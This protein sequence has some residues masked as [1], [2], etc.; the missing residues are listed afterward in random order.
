MI[1][2]YF[3]MGY[4]MLYLWGVL[5]VFVAMPV[6]ADDR[7]P[8]SANVCNL[9][10]GDTI[11]LA[12]KRN[13]TFLNSQLER[14]V[15]KFSLDVTEDR[16]TPKF[17]VG[18]S[19]SWNPQDQR[20]GV[21]AQMRLRVPTGGAFSLSLN[22]NLSKNFDD[23]G[24]Q[25]VSFSQP[26]LKGAWYGVESASVRQAR[27]AEQINI[28]SFRQAAANLVVSVIRAYRSLT[29]AVRAVEISEASLQRAHEQLEA[30]RSLISAGR[31]AQREIGRSEAT[32]ANRELALVQTQNR[33]EDVLF[34][35]RDI[36]ELDSSTQ[37]R[38][39]LEE[40]EVDPREATML[41][42]LEE[43][44]RNRT[45]YLQ[46]RLRI[47]TSR[48]GLMLA[49]NNLLPDLSIQ[50]QWSH[51]NT[52]QTNRQVQM[53][54]SIPL[55]DRAP[56]LGRLQADN[57]LSQ[58]ERS[59]VKLRESIS[60]ELRQ[61][62]NNMKVR[63]RLTELAQDARIL[64][65]KNLAVEEAKFGQGLSSTFEVAS[66]GEE[67]VR[68]EQ[69]EVDAIVSWLEA[70]TELDRVSGRTLDRWGIQ[71]ERVPN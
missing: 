51:N 54:A 45:D 57:A 69:A 20:A 6:V 64:A 32:I 30:T 4:L 39:L 29:A 40:F 28:L 53:N 26:L 25:T 19:A 52:G 65:E 14:E 37:I 12:L 34:N 68:A 11:R 66:S 2:K 23:S 22:E 24:S 5:L 8:C 3:G 36:L 10:L 70:L 46:A 71:L 21:G 56:D 62:S 41:P 38:P 27:I 18:P 35:L 63:L 61:A 13:R 47:E 44:L 33:L 31:V 9:T 15:Q 49:D 55:N 43:V 59:V 7:L 17:S 16:W 50:F 67:L 58:A 48:I 60:N 1:A 42:D